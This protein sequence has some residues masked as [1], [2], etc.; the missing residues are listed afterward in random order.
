MMKPSFCRSFAILERR[1]AAE[2]VAMCKQPPKRNKIDLYSVN[3]IPIG[4]GWLSRLTSGIG[5]IPQLHTDSTEPVNL[6]WH[7][8]W[9]F[10]IFFTFEADRLIGSAG[11]AGWQ[12]L[13]FNS[14]YSSLSHLE[15]LGIIQEVQEPHRQC[16]ML[17][18]RFKMGMGR[19][20]QRS[21]VMNLL[22]TSGPCIG[23]V[24]YR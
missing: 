5:C 1:C 4:K 22:R 15:P 16:H 21:V 6:K 7:H 23:I 9:Y 14:G 10:S 24:R 17:W 20:M 2:D 19:E 8:P 11:V 12:A 3:G 18:N 13:T